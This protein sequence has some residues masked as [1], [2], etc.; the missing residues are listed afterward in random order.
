MRLIDIYWQRKMKEGSQAAE[1][2]KTGGPENRYNLN[3]RGQVK[4]EVLWGGRREN[5]GFGGI[6]KNGG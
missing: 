3:Q 4:T 6:W 1:W 2:G 5:W